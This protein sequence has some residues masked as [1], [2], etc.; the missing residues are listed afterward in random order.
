MMGDGMPS[1]YQILIA[2]GSILLLGL[3]ADAIGKRTIF[4]RVTLLLVFGIIVG[5]QFLDLIPIVVTNQ[6]DLIANI[7]L[8]IV[9]FL[10]GGQISPDVWEKSA[11]KIISISIFAALGTSL[12]V[13]LALVL[14]GVPVEVAILLACISA[15]T[16]PAATVDTVEESGLQNSFTRLLLSVVALDDVW[17]LLLFSLGVT[18][19]TFLQQSNGL[20]EP[21]ITGIWEIG[22]AL[23]LGLGMGW[24]AAFLTGRIKPGRPILTEA[25]GLVFICGGLALWL[26][27]SFLIASMVMGATIRGFAQHHEH[28]FHEIENVEWPFMVIFFVLAGASLEVS[29][30]LNIGLLG[31]VYICARVVGKVAGAQIGSRYGGSDTTSQHWIGLALLPQAG[32]AIGM[33]LVAASRFP[34]YRQLIL[35]LVISTTVIFELFGP[36]STRLVINHMKQK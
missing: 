36:M 15:A 11:R 8:L 13:F 26:G 31:M 6:F 4:P 12:I 24:P 30:T 3:A 19:T 16:A 10:L 25:L 17:A 14:I 22:G 34:E 29:A 23:L 7:T 35:P 20:I 28:A 27:V 18:L 32:V 9:G 2:L 5:E 21:L 33:A 1:N